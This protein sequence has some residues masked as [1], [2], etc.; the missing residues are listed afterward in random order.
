MGEST[1]ALDA[2][3]A[4]VEKRLSL[5]EGEHRRLVMEQAA[6]LKRKLGQAYR[7]QNSHEH[8]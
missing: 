3:L 1:A 4:D 6:L 2:R 5:N 7:F 8:T